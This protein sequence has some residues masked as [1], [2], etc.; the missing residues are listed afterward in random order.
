MTPWK[1]F[2]IVGATLV[3]G[4]AVYLIVARFSPEGGREDRTPTNV[5]AVT[6]GAMSLLIAFTMSSV[7]NDYGTADQASRQEA[8]AV[9]TMNRAALLMQ[10][11]VRDELRNQLVCYAQEVVDIEWPKLQSGDTR[12]VPEIRRT[13]VA[14]DTALAENI[15]AA[16]PGLT[17][18]ENADA[19]RLSAHQA[20]IEVAGNDVPLILWMLLILGSAIT[21]I[22]LFVYADRAKP[23]WG[24]VL[25]IVGPLFI[26][27]ATLVVI[28]FFDHPY[29]RSPDAIE[30]VAMKMVLKNLTRDEVGDVPLP[31]CPKGA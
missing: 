24:H 22:S 14:M 13:F 8:D 25:V 19:Q 16:G 15:D 20:K 17:F 3:I 2:L 12:L 28:A 10:P 6:A 4:S 7:Y 21:I 23:G 1:A 11:P 9:Y 5:Y 26:V 31:H 18:W 29:S 27:S 30:P